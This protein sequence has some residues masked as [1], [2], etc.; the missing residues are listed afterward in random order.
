[1]SVLGFAFFYCADS[2]GSRR[3]AAVTRAV[4][5]GVLALSFG[6]SVYHVLRQVALGQPPPGQADVIAAEKLHQLGEHDGDQLV[7]VGAP[8]NVLDAY[9]ARLSG[10]RVVANV[11]QV[12]AWSPRDSRRLERALYA[13]TARTDARFAVTDQPPPPRA[14]WPPR[15]IR[16]LGA[17]ADLSLRNAFACLPAGRRSGR[18][19]C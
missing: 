15:F 8:S 9:W 18:F 17:S 4:G 12:G 16:L 3:L 14:G 5:I 10:S 1:V 7:Y 2:H 11:V 19:S 6:P 13:V